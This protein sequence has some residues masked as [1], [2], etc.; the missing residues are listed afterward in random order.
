M[1]NIETFGEATPM[2]VAARRLLTLAEVCEFFGGI[3]TTTLYRGMPERYPAPVKIGPN[4]NRW[5]ASE[6]EAA[7]QTLIDQSRAAADFRG[8][9]R[10]VAAP[11]Q[12]PQADAEIR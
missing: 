8:T 3:H 1:T 5:I 11:T 7:L 9:A 4:L 12:A 6:C 2:P 10:N